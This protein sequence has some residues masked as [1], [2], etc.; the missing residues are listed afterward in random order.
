MSDELVKRI[1]EDIGLVGH[2]TQNYGRRDLREL[3]VAAAQKLPETIE[4]Y[5]GAG[6]KVSEPIS[7]LCRVFEYVAGAVNGPSAADAWR[8][9]GD[10]IRAHINVAGSSEDRKEVVRREEISRVISSCSDV[11]IIPEQMQVYYK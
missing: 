1:M 4:R 2:Y 9:A 7:D 8:A 11:A 3:T 10:I 5:H 6:E